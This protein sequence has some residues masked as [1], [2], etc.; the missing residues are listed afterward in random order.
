MFLL[1]VCLAMGNQLVAAAQA[2]VYLAKVTHV[3]DGDTVWVQ[4][5]DGSGARKLRLQ[6]I[7]APEICQAGGDAARTAL[8][9]LVLAQRVQIRVRYHDDY[10]RGLAQVQLGSRDVAATMVRAGHAWSYRWRSKPGPYAAE[11]ALARQQRLGLFATAQPELPRNFRKRHGPCDLV[12][13]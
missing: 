9:E 10:G 13:P 1:V 3:T 4:P 7:D 6:G 12:K 2:E 5:E 8:R 11:E